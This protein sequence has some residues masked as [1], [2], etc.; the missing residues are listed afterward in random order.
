MADTGIQVLQKSYHLAASPFR[1][2]SLC[3]TNIRIFW[4]S[5]D[6]GIL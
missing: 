4:A 6:S 1:K 2:D 5:L 3:K